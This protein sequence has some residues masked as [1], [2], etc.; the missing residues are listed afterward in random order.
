MRFSA[1]VEELLQF[2]CS[3]P[4]TSYNFLLMSWT[5]QDK[6]LEVVE[7]LMLAFLQLSGT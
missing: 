1:A 6:F 5:Y 3:C 2:S 4:G 7:N